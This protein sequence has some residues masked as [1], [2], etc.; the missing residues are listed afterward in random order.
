MKAI[1]LTGIRKMELREIPT[2]RIES[3][4]DVLLKVGSI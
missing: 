2:P 3:D 4:T 1:V